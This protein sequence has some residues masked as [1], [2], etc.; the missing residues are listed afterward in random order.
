MIC[1]EGT[2]LPTQEN[3]FS[4]KDFKAKTNFSSKDF[5]AKNNKTI[6][7]EFQIIEEATS[8]LPLEL[9]NTK[10]DSNGTIARESIATIA[11]DSI[12]VDMGIVQNETGWTQSTE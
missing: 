3:N 10:Q 7:K 11:R 6:V 2:Y 5:K 8:I 4:S 1:A 9:K 12:H